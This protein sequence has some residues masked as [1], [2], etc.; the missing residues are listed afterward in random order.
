MAK[1]QQ[2]QKRGRKAV[3]LVRGNFGDPPAG[4][5]VREISAK[6]PPPRREG[7]D[8]K[9]YLKRRKAESKRMTL[10]VWSVTDAAGVI[11]APKFL[12]AAHPTDPEYGSKAATAAWNLYFRSIVSRLNTS[13]AKHSIEYIPPIPGQRT[14]NPFRD[15]ERLYRDAL[16]SGKPMSR[17]ELA[18]L[19]L[20][21]LGLER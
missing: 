18:K 14:P 15:A 3:P 19:V 12:S 4:I 20:A 10:Q 21:S 16:T 17:E 11:A 7:E 8:S 9:D 5:S 2:K 1:Q 13:N 6:I